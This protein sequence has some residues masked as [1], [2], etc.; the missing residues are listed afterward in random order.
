MFSP[1]GTKVAYT[2]NILGARQ[3]VVVNAADGGNKTV[4]TGHTTGGPISLNWS[5]DGSRIVYG[6]HVD[7]GHLAQPGPATGP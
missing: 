2:E 4:V 3:V 5:P 6:G 1:D 7:R